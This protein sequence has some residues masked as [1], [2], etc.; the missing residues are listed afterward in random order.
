MHCYGGGGGSGGG[1]SGGGGGVCV[2]VR[3]CLRALVCVC[4]CRRNALR[5]RVSCRYDMSGNR[6]VFGTPPTHTEGQFWENTN[7]LNTGNN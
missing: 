1:G 2:C 7:A 3:A 4:V 5:G 6:K